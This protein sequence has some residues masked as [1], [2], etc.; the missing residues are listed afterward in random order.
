MHL[1]IDDVRME[2]FIVPAAAVDTQ[3][4]LEHIS[5]VL[6]FVQSSHAP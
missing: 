2:L 3:H 4:P 5:V 6:L 1:D